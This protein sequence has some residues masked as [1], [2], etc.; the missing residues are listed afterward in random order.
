MQWMSFIGNDRLGIKASETTKKKKSPTVTPTPQFF[1]LS[2]HRKEKMVVS[3]DIMLMKNAVGI[4]MDIKAMDLAHAVC[5]LAPF[6]TTT[7]MDTKS[8]TNYHRVAEQSL[9]SYAVPA[10]HVAAIGIRQCL[11]SG[12]E[13]N[14]SELQRHVKTFCAEYIAPEYGDALDTECC[15]ILVD[16]LQA[17]RRQGGIQQWKRV[18]LH[19]PVH[20]LLTSDNGNLREFADCW[21]ELIERAA[22]LQ[23]YPFP[24]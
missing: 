17:D 18:G 11:A 19:G 21:L 3:F 14:V 12:S 23:S 13:M 9:E 10:T 6:A 2:L 5:L 22:R 24:G 1:V 7:P 4:G 16:L 15:Q 20:M 8:I